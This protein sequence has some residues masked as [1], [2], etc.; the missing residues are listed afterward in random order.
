M[1]DIYRDG[2]EMLWAYQEFRVLFQGMRYVVLVVIAVLLIVT[3]LHLVYMTG[4]NSLLYRSRS[5]RPGWNRRFFVG[6]ALLIAVLAGLY[7]LSGQWIVLS[8]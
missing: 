8:S 3:A 1:L 5:P 7:W 2:F 6:T 4:R